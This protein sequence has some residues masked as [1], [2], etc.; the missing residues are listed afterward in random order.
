[1]QIGLIGSGKMAQAMGG[2]LLKRGYPI[3][4]LWGRNMES[5]L[6]AGRYLHL[7]PTACLCDLVAKADILLLAV[8]DDAIEEV[9][10]AVSSCGSFHG[11]WIGHFS[12]SRSLDVLDS[13]AQK[14]ASVFSLHPLQT[15]PEPDQGIKSLA[16]SAFMLEA[17]E[18]LRNGLKEW[19]AP[20]KNRLG[21]IKPG[22][23]AL[24]HL[25]AC[26]ASNYVMVLYHLAEE[27]LRS[28]GI[29]E[30]ISREALLPLMKG[31]LDNYRSLGALKGLTGPVSRG[32]WGTVQ[33]HLESLPDSA[34][35]AREAL[36]R[37][38]GIEALA[39]TRISGRIS[40]ESAA[41]MERII[42]GGSTPCEKK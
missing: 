29:P 17:E 15:V 24:Y 27:A 38:L 22:K 10:K 5:A 2:Y 36:I 26:L 39:M 16:E 37:D 14:G 19:L 4:G 11:K 1:M 20:C 32:D 3:S 35:E 28:S 7:E 12:G 33:K 41:E 30:D 31:T 6:A 23:K 18:A 9:A 21:W 40:E 8:S 34:L 25:G 13:V 42:R